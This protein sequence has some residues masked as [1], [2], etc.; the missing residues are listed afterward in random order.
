MA[1]HP[2]VSLSWSLDYPPPFAHCWALHHN[3]LFAFVREWI[4]AIHV[5]MLRQQYRAVRGEEP[6]DARLIM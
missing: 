5:L 3:C 4:S 1:Y 2:A 6:L